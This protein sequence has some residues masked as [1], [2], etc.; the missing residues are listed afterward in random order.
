MNIVETIKFR[1]PLT[2]GCYIAVIADAPRPREI[3]DRGRHGVSFTLKV[4]EGDAKGRLAAI[5]LI[6]QASNRRVDRDL[7][8]LAMWCDCLGVDSAASL[9]ELMAKLQKAAIGKRLEFT[10]QRND[11][12]GG[13]D[14]HLTAV[15]LA[16]EGGA[17]G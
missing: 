1:A 14:L 3:N 15:R 8:V 9:I 12:R 6:V 5:D 17:S 13:V 11:W 16:P 4:I 7:E 10:I 2:D